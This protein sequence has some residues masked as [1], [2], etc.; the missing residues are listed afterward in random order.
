MQAEP[1]KVF[2]RDGLLW[3]EDMNLG[4]YPLEHYHYNL[5]DLQWRVAPKKTPME[6]VKISGIRV[7]PL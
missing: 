3:V 5:C 6:L 4:S 1:V 2:K 7:K